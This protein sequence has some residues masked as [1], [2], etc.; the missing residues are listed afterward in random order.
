MLQN[1]RVWKICTW[2]Y[3]TKIV[4]LVSLVPDRGAGRDDLAYFYRAKAKKDAARTPA[5][6]ANEPALSISPALAKMTVPFA[7]TLP[8]LTGKI[9]DPPVT[10]AFLLTVEMVVRIV[11]GRAATTTPPTAEG[12]HAPQMLDVI[13]DVM[14]IVGSL[15]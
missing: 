6:M 12:V 15:L 4:I 10:V 1:E 2:Y 11:V 3:C 13:V 5:E 7:L 14:T 9:F 8:R